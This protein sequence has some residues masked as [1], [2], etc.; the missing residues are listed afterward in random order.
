MDSKVVEKVIKGHFQLLGVEFVRDLLKGVDG[1]SL[2]KDGEIV[3]T[4]KKKDPLL[5]QRVVER[6]EPITGH[7]SLQII[8][9]L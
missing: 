3:V 6:F 1:I 5:L 7:I 9:H 8:K 2:T 4:P